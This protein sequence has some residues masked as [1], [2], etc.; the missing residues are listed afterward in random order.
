MKVLTLIDLGDRLAML[1]KAMDL[2]QKDLAA[3]LNVNQNFISRF[4]NGKGGSIE[5]LFTLFNFYRQHF[6]LNTLL[7]DEFEIIRKDDPDSKPNTFHSIAVERLKILQTD[8]GQNINEVIEII[9]KQG[10]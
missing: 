4:E 6:H 8:F 5:F 3:T 1:R 7:S 9:E 10:H 2:Y